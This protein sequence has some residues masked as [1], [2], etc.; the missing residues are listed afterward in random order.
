MQWPKKYDGKKL[1]SQNFVINKNCV[2]K[3]IC[4]I[5]FAIKKIVF[6]KCCD[7]NI[8]LKTK[9]YLLIVFM[10]FSYC[11]KKRMK[12]ILCE[13]NVVVMRRKIGMKRRKKLWW[14]KR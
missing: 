9:I 14:Q 13:E 6:G 8:V 5:N 1:W 10:N 4:W 7:D 11:E 12:K 2:G 3:K